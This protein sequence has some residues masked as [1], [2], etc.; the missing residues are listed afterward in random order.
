MWKL[1]FFYNN[2]LK[3][4]IEKAIT[5][6]GEKPLV[7]IDDKLQ[8]LPNGFVGTLGS[9]AKLLEKFSR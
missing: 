8:K 5:G 1:I 9:W 3:K 7:T 6:C 2:L 4:S